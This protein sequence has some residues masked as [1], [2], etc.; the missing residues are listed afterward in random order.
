[1]L[2]HLTLPSPL[3]LREFGRIA[4]ENAM[5]RVALETFSKADGRELVAQAGTAEPT[6][7]AW[8]PS[9]LRQLLV[10]RFSS[11]VAAQSG[12]ELLQLLAPRPGQ[13]IATLVLGIGTAAGWWSAAVHYSGALYPVTALRLVGPGMVTLEP[14]DR[15]AAASPPSPRPTALAAKPATAK[16]A[17]AI[18]KEATAAAGDG[19]ELVDWSRVRGALGDQLFDR[20]RESSVALIGASRN[21]SFAAH[22]FAMLG[23]R[24]LILIDPDRDEAHHLTSTLGA[25]RDGID[26]WKV[27]NRAASLRRFRGDLG[28]ATWNRSFPDPETA[29]A[30]IN[31]DLIC[32]CTDDDLPRLAAAYWAQTHCRPH[33]DIGSGVF[34]DPPLADA[35]LSPSPPPTDR[36]PVPPSIPESS[37]AGSAARRKGLDVQLALPG[38]SCVACLAGLRQEAEAWRQLQEPPGMLS[39]RPP[40]SWQSQR[41]GSLPTVNAIAANLGVQIWLELLA[42]VISTSVWLR[43]EWDDG[44]LPTVARRGPAAGPCRVCRPPARSVP[45]A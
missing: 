2:F 35:S 39:N 5:I 22:A 32:T 8:R 42:G 26:D 12:P 13:L 6:D 44:G 25:S 1:M 28:L 33:L 16:P 15:S 23:V 24:S 27:A 38:E 10:V 19:G 20:V 36:H 11:H 3:W 9:D 14:T 21:G 43:M 7:A 45:A 18:P 40:Q 29:A 41:A 37:A 4:R 17:T 30:I 34:V 31:A